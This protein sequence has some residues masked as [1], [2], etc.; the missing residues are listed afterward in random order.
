MNSKCVCIVTVIDPDTQ[1]PVEIEIRKLDNGAMV[2][3]DGSWLEQC[4]EDEQ[5]NNP[6]DDGTFTV[7]ADEMTPPDY[8]TILVL[9]SNMGEVHGAV[10]VPFSLVSDEHAMQR[11]RSLAEH[12]SQEIHDDQPEPACGTIEEVEAWIR[13]KNGDDDTA[14]VAMLDDEDEAEEYGNDGHA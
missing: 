4:D 14:I 13:E 11:I 2:G 8:Y 10:S 9:A 1:A 7:S 5:P 3:L 6:Y 12:Y